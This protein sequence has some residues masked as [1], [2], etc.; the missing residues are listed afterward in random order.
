MPILYK[1]VMKRIRISENCPESSEA[2]F[3]TWALGGG[4]WGPQSHG[5]SVK[6][7]HAAI[8]GGINHFDTAPVYGKGQAEML[9][10]QQLRKNR[11]DFILA[12]KCFYKDP[13]DF[14]KSFRTSLKRLNTSYIDI[15]YIHWPR[16]NTDM[17]PVMELMERYRKEGLIRAI[18]VSNFSVAEMK[19]VLEA[20]DIDIA[21]FGYNLLW[22][23][24]EDELIPF[25]RE[26]D[27]TTASYSILAQG[28]LTGKFS[29]IPE[30]E[31]Y[32]WRKKM[33]LFDSQIF[34][35]VREEVENLKKIAE[36]Y[37]MSCA[38]AS[39]FWTKENQLID[40]SILGSRDRAQ[41][42]ENLKPFS[43]Y[44]KRELIEEM[45]ALS[46]RIKPLIP[47]ENNIFRHKT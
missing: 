42:E 19:Q 47:K 17:R 18:G 37:K 31:E 46:E 9:I 26:K 15:F 5:D 28:I 12:S 24:E 25:C 36:K 1:L 10:G 3:G 41:I 2:V 27:I 14:D 35:A 23:R 11:E 6:A 43:A 13:A 8:R 33:V 4:Y 30:G 34:P 40:C 7:I 16:S 21:Q 38:E 32:S 20:G 29:T 44:G 22:R 39:I 45:N